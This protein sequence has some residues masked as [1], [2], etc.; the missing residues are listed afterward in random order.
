MPTDKNYYDDVSTHIFKIYSC[1]I[2][3][4]L[5]DSLHNKLL[6]KCN[7]ISFIPSGLHSFKIRYNLQ[8]HTA[9]YGKMSH[10]NCQE[11]LRLLLHNPNLSQLNPFV[12][13][14]LFF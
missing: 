12:P 14:R 13:S 6:Q 1:T 8:H 10:S 11:T 9:E 4:N 3:C 5:S 2:L 7:V